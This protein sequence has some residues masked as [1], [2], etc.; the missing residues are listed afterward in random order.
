MVAVISV[1]AGQRFTQLVIL[2]MIRTPVPV[3][4]SGH[5]TA[6][7]SEEGMLFCVAY[8]NRS[9]RKSNF[10]RDGYAQDLFIYF[11][12]YSDETCQRKMGN[13]KCIN[14]IAGPIMKQNL[15]DINVNR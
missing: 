10:A 2:G 7:V 4:C 5:C 9:R 12:K 14:N 11:R 13:V 8:V 15:T 1:F 6:E 3:H